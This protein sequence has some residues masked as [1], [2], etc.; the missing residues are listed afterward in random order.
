MNNYE[1]VMVQL[2]E[3]VKEVDELRTF[4]I[5]SSPHNSKREQYYD[6]VNKVQFLME[7]MIVF[8]SEEEEEIY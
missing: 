6:L 5:E 1:E 3:M 2:S 4:L 8:E 7:E